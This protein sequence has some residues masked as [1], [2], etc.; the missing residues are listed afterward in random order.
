MKRLSI[1]SITYE[2]SV[3]L[4]ATLR[5]ISEQTANPSS[6]EVIVVDGASS[7]ATTRLINSWGA[8]N[9]R[10]ISEPDEGVYDAMNKGLAS[11]RGQYVQ[12]LNSGDTYRD[13]TALDRILTGLE[14]KPKWLITG[15]EH[16]MGAVRSPMIIQ[17]RPHSWIRHALGL[18]PHCHQACVFERN[19]L[20]A[21]GGHSLDHDFI[22]DFDAILCF[23]LVA[24]P[25]T[26]D[27]IDIRYEG[28][29]ISH[30]RHSE[31]PALQHKV[32]VSRMQLSGVT[33][34]LDLGWS[35]YRAWRFRLASRLRGSKAAA[36]TE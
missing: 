34:T 13:T 35:V 27:S 9:M 7:A 21:L 31:I 16:S 36:T 32:R 2:D 11:A 26:L 4:E 6:F 33:L 12:F 5:S 30:R 24:T 25:H 19:T 17:N 14:N 8:D 23:G 15:A 29:G 1:V 20:E 18:Q 10:L 22:A 3:G 28:G